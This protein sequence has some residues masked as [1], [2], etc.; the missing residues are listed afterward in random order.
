MINILGLN[1]KVY[2]LSMIFN[3]RNYEH[4]TIHQNYVEN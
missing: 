2:A 1:N 3:G 4:I